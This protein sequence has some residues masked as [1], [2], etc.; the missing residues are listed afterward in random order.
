MSDVINRM[1]NKDLLLLTARAYKGGGT[2]YL[3]I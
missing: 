3:I 2:D 1:V